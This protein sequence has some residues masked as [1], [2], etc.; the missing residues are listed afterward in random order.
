MLRRNVT[1]PKGTTEQAILTF[2]EH[3]IP[4]IIE[5]GAKAAA[6]RAAAL[7]DELS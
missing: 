3:R 2:D 1:S 5:A 7:S 4:A 6:A